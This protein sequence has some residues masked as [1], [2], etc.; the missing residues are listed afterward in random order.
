MPLRRAAG[1]TFAPMDEAIDAASEGARR[2]IRLRRTMQTRLQGV[3]PNS[4]G[5]IFL[6]DITLPDLP[7]ITLPART[8][9][10]HKRLCTG[11]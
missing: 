9:S 8:A 6:G 10:A 4:Q 11:V 3:W 5:Q 7:G 1:R 2:L